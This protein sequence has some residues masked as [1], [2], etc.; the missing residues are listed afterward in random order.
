MEIEPVNTRKK[1][2]I[3]SF[4]GG[5]ARMVIQ[6]YIMLRIIEK[7]PNL[8]E[9]VSVYAGTSAGAIL[10]SYF[11]TNNQ[12]DLVSKKTL[13]AIFSRSCFRK[14]ISLGGMVKSKYT[15]KHLRE[16][17]ESLVGEA[18]LGQVQKGLF[19]PVFHATK[20]VNVEKQENPHWSPEPSWLKA[21]VP[22]W[23][24]QYKHNLD[25]GVVSVGNNLGD[26]SYVSEK[27]AE[28]ILQSAAAPYY[29]PMCGEYV[30]GGIGN[31][32]PSL[33]ILT[34]LIARGVDGRDIY[35]LSIGSG[36]TPLSIDGENKD[37]GAA[38]WLPYLL[39]MTFDASEEVTSQQC[40]DLLRDR[41]WRIQPVLEHA[42]ALDDTHAF[43]K[44][45]SIAGNHDLRHTF[46]WLEKLMKVF[47][48]K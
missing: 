6:Y 47:P 35:I 33:S 9:K 11:A 7:F 10:A 40:Y 8:L 22:R 42:I 37:W 27:L 21:R 3:I 13:D 18:T 30:D 43:D 23:G 19:I 34:K 31:N 12:I 20:D 14:L 24:P 46:D 28:I 25:S 4:D 41:F 16:V 36:E 44:L 26:N 38:Q 17:V 1:H 39:N 29:F 45:V 5:G 48:E 15:S 2:L 32:N